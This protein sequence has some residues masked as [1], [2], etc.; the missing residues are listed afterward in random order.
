M[1]TV[2]GKRKPQDL[3]ATHMKVLTRMTKNV[4]KESSVGKV[5]IDISVNL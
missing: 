5:E 4:G 1:A 2:L 3:V